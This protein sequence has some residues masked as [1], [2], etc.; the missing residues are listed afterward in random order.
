M[1]FSCEFSANFLL[2]F[3]YF[4]AIYVPEWFA[5]R[6]THTMGDDAVS[7]STR[8]ILSHHGRAAQVVVCDTAE[9]NSGG[10]GG[11]RTAST[12]ECITA[13]AG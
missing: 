4:T 10:A 13:A 7:R 12:V 2:I 3:C 1:M 6:A 11:D 5:N 8:L 9:V